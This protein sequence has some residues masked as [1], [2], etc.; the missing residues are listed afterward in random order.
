MLILGLVVPIAQADT[1]PDAPTITQKKPLGSDFL[2]ITFRNPSTYGFMIS[3]YDIW[4]SDDGGINFPG[5]F[6]A[7][8]P[9]DPSALVYLRIPS[10]S[11][12][13]R[14]VKVRL[15]TSAGPGSWSA[16]VLMYTN[17]ARAM[18]VYVQAPDGTPIIGGSITWTMPTT[19]SGGSAHSSVTYGLTSDG[20]I[21]LPS[22]PAGEATFTLV[23]GELPNGVLVSGQLGAILGYKSTVLHIV[24]PPDAMHVV[25]VVMPNGLPISDVSVDV[26]STD[27]TDTQTRQGFTFA[28][29]DSGLLTATP[30]NGPAAEPS[31][32]PTSTT[33][34][35]PAPSSSEE[36]DAND[37]GSDVI[38]EANYDEYYW[39][40]VDFDYFWVSW[41]SWL[42]QPFGNLHKF[43]S[44]GS[45]PRQ[46]V[47][48]EGNVVASGKTNAM[49]RFVVKGFTNTVPT[50]T[51]S[52]DDGVIAQSQTVQL[53]FALTTVELPYAPFV[54]AGLSSVTAGV[55]TAALIPVAVTDVSAQ[56]AFRQWAVAL[57]GS[58]TVVP[59]KTKFKI[60]PPKGAPKG[61]CNGVASTYT[62]GSNGKV[63]A[64]VCATVSGNYLVK[65]LT[66]GVRSLGA[67]QVNVRGGAPSAVRQLRGVSKKPGVLF[68]SWKTPQYL[69]GKTSTHYR[70]ELRIP[71]HKP[72][73]K[74][75]TIP[76]LTL[77]GLKH[78]KSYTVAV[79]AVTRYG[80]SQ[81]VRIH[82]PIV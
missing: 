52:Y 82:C 62:T 71:G 38:D 42:R 54:S 67:V 53:Q 46:R 70:V 61:H 57:R 3:G 17:G 66:P 8:A 18:R 55:D 40:Y 58:A 16:P 65:S 41:I 64:R 14:F 25:N 28:L 68:L 72:I 73:F 24:R 32:T 6:T 5:H 35:T 43:V 51:V 20:Y 33:E 76:T 45:A 44:N 80:K 22:A 79:V 48:T 60:V 78:A 11:A 21:D 19:P 27:M 81:N 10:S 47:V 7:P 12:V 26:N 31:P 34:P 59:G 30:D 15:N 36:P 50:A 56:A 2:D 63:T 9:T 77:R 49:G 4:T 29:P 39:D 1:A 23:N 69:G 13:A 75:T 74:S 37:Y